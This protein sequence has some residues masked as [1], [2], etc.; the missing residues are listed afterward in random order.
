M[1]RAFYPP[2]R[3]APV[4]GGAYVAVVVLP[5][6]EGRLVAFDVDDPAAR[7]RWFPWTPLPR[8]TQPWEV[9]AALVEEW[10]GV[11]VADLRLVDALGLEGL[12][13]SWQL[14]L[15]F[16]AELLGLPRGGARR[17]PVELP[18]HSLGPTAGFAPADLL[19]WASEGPRDAPSPPTSTSPRLF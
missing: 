3:E 17:R 11:D 18:L 13:G 8:E 9:A 19:R 10:C 6:R 4:P 7:G 2:P 15:V 16:R 12:G 5:V 14:T 1:S